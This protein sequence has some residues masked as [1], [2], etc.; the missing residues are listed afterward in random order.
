MAG[1]V[2]DY[3]FQFI[4]AQDVNE[5]GADKKIAGFADNTGDASGWRAAAEAPADE[6]TRNGKSAL[7][8]IS[9]QL[10]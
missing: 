8:T 5:F 6:N 4:V 2:G 1:F 9:F 10:L 7:A 3:R